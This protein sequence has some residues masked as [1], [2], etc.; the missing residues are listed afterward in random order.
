T[1]TKTSSRPMRPSAAR[2][3]PRAPRLNAR[4][5]A[6]DTYDHAIMITHTE[7]PRRCPNATKGPTNAVFD[8]LR[9]R[10]RLEPLPR[11][12]PR[13]PAGVLRNA[14]HDDALGAWR[15]CQHS[16]VARA[17]PRH[18]RAALCLAGP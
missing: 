8:R 15:P 13:R 16:R 5:G 3:A 11:A 9:R 18:A 2:E 17:L 7:Q 14:R 6:L 1:R 4:D 12:W 10:R